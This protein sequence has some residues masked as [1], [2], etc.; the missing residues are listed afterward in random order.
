[1]ISQIDTWFL[2]YRQQLILRGTDTDNF[3]EVMFHILKDI[4][5]ERTKAFYRATVVRLDYYEFN[6]LQ[7]LF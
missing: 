4:P 2:L 6:R 7:S 5:L 3:S 1:M